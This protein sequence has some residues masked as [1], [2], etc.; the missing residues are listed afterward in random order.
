MNPVMKLPSKKTNTFFLLK[1]LMLRLELF[2]GFAREAI[3]NVLK[4]PAIIFLTMPM[5]VPPES[6]AVPTENGC[7]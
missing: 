3:L 6:I 5:C 1:T 2:P 7:L 4:T